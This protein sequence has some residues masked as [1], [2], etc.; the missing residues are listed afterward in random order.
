MA[1]LFL[2]QYSA[3]YLFRIFNRTRV[4]IRLTANSQVLILYRCQH[5]RSTSRGE[6]LRIPAFVRMSRAERTEVWYVRSLQ[7]AVKEQR[8]NK[9][10]VTAGSGISGTGERYVS[11]KKELKNMIATGIDP[12]R[13]VDFISS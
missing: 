10:P 9:A 3:A 5:A 8:L 2:R 1:N 13:L 7:G 11:A 6:A 12:G 4:T